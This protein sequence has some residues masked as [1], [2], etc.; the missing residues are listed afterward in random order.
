MSRFNQHIIESIRDKDKH[1]AYLKE[2]IETLESEKRKLR[3]KLPRLYFFSS[4][5]RNWD[6]YG[7]IICAGSKEFCL[8]YI[9]A[10][11]PYG[12]MVND[13][14]YSDD[15]MDGGIVL[16]VLEYCTEIERRWAW[17][18]EWLKEQEDKK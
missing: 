13:W 8:E 7:N 11:F 17:C 3:D 5:S 4:T 2:Q 16:G 10:Q 6:K 18:Q 1:I 12:A 9:K 14:Q 15:T